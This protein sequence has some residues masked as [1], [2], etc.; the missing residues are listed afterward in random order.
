MRRG[1]R[2][3]SID[4]NGNKKFAE[5][6]FELDKIFLLRSKPSIIN[7]NAVA[8]DSMLISQDIKLETIY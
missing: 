4:V 1:D 6:G 8:N 3:Q 5:K 7:W 2:R